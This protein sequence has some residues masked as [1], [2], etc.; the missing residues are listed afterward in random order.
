MNITGEHTYLFFRVKI[1]GITHMSIKAEEIISCQTWFNTSAKYCIEF[2]T[3]HT[4]ILFEY[5]SK[6]KWLAVIKILEDNLII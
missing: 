2:Q 1:D 4:S 5:D 6:D 3:N